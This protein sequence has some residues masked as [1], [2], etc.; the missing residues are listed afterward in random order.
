MNRLYKDTENRMLGGVCAGIADYTG[1]DITVI[2]VLTAISSI[3]YSPLC[4]V[5]FLLML[6]L[7]DKSGITPENSQGFEEFLSSLRQKNISGYAKRAIIIIAAASALILF[8]EIIFHIDIKIKYIAIFGFIILGLCLITTKDLHKNP[9]R[10]VFAGSAI[11]IFMLI[12]LASITGFMYFPI[13]I[14]ISAAMNLWPLFLAGIGLS[15]LFQDKRKVSRLWILIL[16]ASAAITLINGI[17]A[18]FI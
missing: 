9:S 16:G 3:I 13:A 5:Y 7:P 8:L 14:I 17:M 12:W 6:V 1:T 15:L 10:S 2:R 4:A 18:I 11:C